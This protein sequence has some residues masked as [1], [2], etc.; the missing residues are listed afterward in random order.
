M[1]L[2]K[3]SGR[4]CRCTRRRGS[5]QCQPFRMPV[6]CSCRG[7]ARV[8]P[9]RSTWPTR[10]ARTCAARSISRRRSRS[11]ACRAIR[12]RC[13]L[14]GPA[15]VVGID[16]HE[17]VR[18]DPKPNTTDFEPNY[19]PGIEFDRPDFPWLFTP[20]KAGANA[21][22]R[23]W[24]CLVVVRQQE[25]VLLSS[26]ADA[27]LPILNINGPAKPADEL[28]DL[29]DSWAWVHAQV[30]A[31]SLAEADPN[32]AEERH[33]DA[34]GALALAPAVPADS[35]AEHRLRRLRRADVRAGSQGR[36]R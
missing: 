20:A 19:F 7:C 6:S 2:A 15:D 25:G 27:P 11:T 33:A 21:K 10:S 36:A 34:A 13:G 31:S 17:I 26:S 1:W 24:L 32:A 16:P 29:V 30:A 5:K 22:L 23:P 3:R 12:S 35:A 18:V 28:P 14:R 9:P 8:L 4:S